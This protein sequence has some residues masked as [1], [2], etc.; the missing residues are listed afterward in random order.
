MKFEGWNEIILKFYLSHW[1]IA[2]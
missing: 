2:L 1:L